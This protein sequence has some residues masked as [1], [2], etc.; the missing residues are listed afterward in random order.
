MSIKIHLQCLGLLFI[1]SIIQISAC[2]AASGDHLHGQS[3]A[4]GESAD[5]YD[6]I[7]EKGVDGAA[8]SKKTMPR[9]NK[10]EQKKPDTR[11]GIDRA[12]S[13]AGNNRV[14]GNF[15]LSM[16]KQTGTWAVAPEQKELRP[17]EDKIR[18]QRHVFGAYAGVDAGENFN[19]GIG[20]EL[21]LKD[22]NHS[23][24]AA[25]SDQPDSAFGLGLKFKFGF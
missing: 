2:F 19:L 4:F 17:D 18:D 24:E 5:R 25:S 7:W 12:L 23:S 3:W 13:A 14:R 9:Q 11:T 1:C 10:A 21:I 16:Q 8:I 15:N 22:E 20:P 6:A